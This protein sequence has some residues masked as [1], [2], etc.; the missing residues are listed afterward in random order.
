MISLLEFDADI[1]GQCHAG[2]DLDALYDGYRQRAGG[3]GQYLPRQLV[4]LILTIRHFQSGA[5]IDIPQSLVEFLDTRAFALYDA[6]HFTIIQVC[7]DV[8]C[9]PADAHVNMR[10]DLWFFLGL[11]IAHRITLNG[12]PLSSEVS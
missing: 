2:S 7:L 12:R 11:I 9:E 1:P 3:M 8:A 4:D 5:G 6:S 10:F